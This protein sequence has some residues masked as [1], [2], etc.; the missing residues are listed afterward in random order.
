MRLSFITVKKNKKK[1]LGDYGS[2][3]VLPQISTEIFM[4]VFLVTLYAQSSYYLIVLALFVVL[5]LLSTKFP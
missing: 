4:L 1:L 3:D 2:F 5:V